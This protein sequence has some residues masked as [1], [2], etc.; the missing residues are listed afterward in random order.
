M[1]YVAMRGSA[2]A[3]GVRRLHGDVSR[4]IF[5]SVFPRWPT[6]EVPIGHVTNGIHTPS[7][8]STTADELSAKQCG[9]ER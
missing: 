3:N 6:A 9:E 7:W 2:A 5:K 8:E 1:A 4:H